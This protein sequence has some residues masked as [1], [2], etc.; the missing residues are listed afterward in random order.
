MFYL[1]TVL[2]LQWHGT[3]D[4]IARYDQDSVVQETRKGQTFRKRCWK[5]P[6]SNDGVRQLW[7]SKQINNPGTRRQLILKIKRTS[8][9]FDRKAFGLKFVKRATRI[10]S[11]LR[12][13]SNCAL[14]RDRP[15]PE[16]KIKD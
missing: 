13:M 1:C 7:S 10:S 6:E 8:E 11:G 5:G 2:E 9:E 16:R 3:G 15:P 12:K 4:T 14:W